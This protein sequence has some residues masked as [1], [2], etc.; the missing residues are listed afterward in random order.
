MY[1]S[2]LGVCWSQNLQRFKRHT[3]G[4]VTLKLALKLARIPHLLHE[5][6]IGMCAAVT[7]QTQRVVA[8]R[9]FQRATSILETNAGDG[10]ILL[11]ST[12][13]VFGLTACG[14]ATRNL[15]TNVQT[16]SCSD[17][18]SSKYIGVCYNSKNKKW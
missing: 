11:S 17:L 2:G 4:A 8:P 13:F 6:S 9:R 16:P 7:F 12:R 14:F 18:Q 15:N 3:R 1:D 5:C 10:V